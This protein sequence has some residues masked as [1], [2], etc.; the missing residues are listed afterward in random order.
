L[1]GGQYGRTESQ[2]YRRHG[3]PS[4]TRPRRP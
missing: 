1:A 4:A 2:R 3:K